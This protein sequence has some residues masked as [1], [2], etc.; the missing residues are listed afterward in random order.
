MANRLKLAKVHSIQVLHARGWSQRRI[1]RELGIHRETVARYVQIAEGDPRDGPGGTNPA[2]QNRPNPPTGSHDQNRP[3]P[4]TGSVGPEIAAGDPTSVV[5][6]RSPTS[7]VS[8]ASA[9]L[10]VSTSVPA[11]KHTPSGTMRRAAPTVPSAA[12]SPAQAPVRLPRALG[13][14][15]KWQNT[16]RPCQHSKRSDDGPPP[17]LPLATSRLVSDSTP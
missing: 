14:A 10:G 6:T 16:P 7:I 1:A 13:R 9:P 3:D 17:K 4:P 11:T 12:M 8:I 5:S 2:G 15:C